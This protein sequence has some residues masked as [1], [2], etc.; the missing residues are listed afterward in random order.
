[1]LFVFAVKSL[2]PRAQE[3]KHLGLVSSLLAFKL[4]MIFE[5]NQNLRR[6]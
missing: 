2:E 1:M 6:R 4:K 5:S 3:A